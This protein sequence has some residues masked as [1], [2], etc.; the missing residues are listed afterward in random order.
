MA[1]QRLIVLPDEDRD[2]PIEPLEETER[3]AYRIEKIQQRLDALDEKAEWHW[4]QLF[5]HF[6]K[7]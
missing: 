4:I 2:P 1:P 5:S 3:R 7:L 6:T